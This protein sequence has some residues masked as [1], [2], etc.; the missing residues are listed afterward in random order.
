MIEWSLAPFLGDAGCRGVVVAIAAGDMH[1]PATRGRLPRP[2]REAQGG[3]T[4]SDSVRSGLAA[5]RA[6]RAD[7]DDWV[8]VHDAARPC[9]TPAE[10]DALR[11]AVTADAGSAGGLLAL[12]LADTLKR[13]DAGHGAVRS[14]DTLARESLWRALTPQMFRL[15]ALERALQAAAAAGRSPTDEAQALEWQGVAP[16]LVAGEATNLKVTTQ[17]DVTLATAI[18][19]ARGPDAAAPGVAGVV[20]AMGRGVGT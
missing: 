10:I 9:I 2:V 8:L 14:V 4:R 13:G 3:A 20:S 12:P 1:W 19:A 17:A 16:R 18:L 5:L 11:A 7:D 15:G 6:A